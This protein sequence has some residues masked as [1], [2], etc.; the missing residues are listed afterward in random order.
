MGTKTLNLKLGVSYRFA[1]AILWPTLMTTT[2]RD[3]QGGQHLRQHGQ[4]IVV[5]P[6]HIS[7]V[8][9]L[10]LA[11]FLH[12]LGRPPRFMAKQ[13]VFDV[14]MLGPI[15]HNAGQVPVVR[16]RDPHKSLAQAADAV[17]AGECVVVYPEGTITRDPQLWPMTGKTGAL[18]LALETGSP[19]I[20][21]AQWG[22]QEIMA[23]YR[24][25]LRLLPPKT[26]QIRAGEPLPIDD[27]RGQQMTVPLL[28]EGTD[29]LMDAITAML[30]DLRG[31]PA[32]PQRL[33]WAAEQRRRA[34]D[35]TK[36]DN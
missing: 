15:L 1:E 27:L 30:A 18:R 26:V 25:R 28:K 7:F 16:D 4:G 31:T 24:K 14:P 11:H 10:V 9:P 21:I 22:A 6:N 20:P 19:L 29:R 32:P 8:D 33:N 23:P 3:W 13:S 17:T 35:P 36:E 12:D 5:A 34:A 2:R